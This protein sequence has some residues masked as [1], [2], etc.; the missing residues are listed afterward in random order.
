MQIHLRPEGTCI[1]CVMLVLV[2]IHEQCEGPGRA[3]ASGD[4]YIHEDRKR[5]AIPP[6]VTAHRAEARMPLGMQQKYR[7][8]EV[9]FDP[10]L[11]VRGMEEGMEG[12]E[13]GFVLATHARLTGVHTW[14]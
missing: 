10:N 8:G 1:W 5:E 11:Q 13:G 12:W 14:I 4:R 6:C 7:L 2:S 9:S 3:I